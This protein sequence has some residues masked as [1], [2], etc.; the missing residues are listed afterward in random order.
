MFRPFPE[1]L[2][3]IMFHYGLGIFPLPDQLY[4]SQAMGISPLAYL[5][6]T[7]VKQNIAKGDGKY[8]IL[9]TLNSHHILSKSHSSPSL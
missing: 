2:E 8:L 4:S 3:A 5:E 6:E 9:L 1:E 7:G